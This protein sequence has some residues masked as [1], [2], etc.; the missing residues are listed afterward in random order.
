MR[1]IYKCLIVLLLFTAG[2]VYAQSGRVVV[3]FTS[4]LH[5]CAEQYPKIAAIIEQ[6]REA[7]QQRGEAFYLLD[8]GDIAM[9]SEFHAVIAQQAV[10]YRAMARMGYDAF[11]Y[12]NHDFDFG[13][14]A[15][16]QMFKS[17]WEQ[18]H[19]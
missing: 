2:S 6:E 14:Q 10:E 15:F 9:G 8:A 12:G 17:A 19:I 1:H 7:A 18:E 3:L 16:A 13:E 5:S 4:D 11:I